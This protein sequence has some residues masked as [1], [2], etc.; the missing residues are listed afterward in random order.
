MSLLNIY[1][2]VDFNAQRRDFNGPRRILMAF[3]LIE[4]F[5]KGKD[6]AG[7]ELVGEIEPVQGLEEY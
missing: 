1:F 3:A 6:Q 7:L 4:A 2:V 5:L